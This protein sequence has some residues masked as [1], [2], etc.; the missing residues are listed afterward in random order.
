MLFFHR[1]TSF[2]RWDNIDLQNPVSRKQIKTDLTNPVPCEQIKSPIKKP[3]KKV[4]HITQMHN[5]EHF[6]ITEEKLGPQNVEEICQS[7]FLVAQELVKYMHLPIISEDATK[8]DES[9]S[10]PDY[11]ACN[12]LILAVFPEGL[13]SYYED[14]DNTQKEMLYRIGGIR[15]LHYLGQIPTL[16]SANTH[17]GMT[18]DN[19]SQFRSIRELEAVCNAYLITERLNCDTAVIVYGV[20]HVKGFK[21]L[22]EK[23]AVVYEDVNT[24]FNRKPETKPVLGKAEVT[25]LDRLIQPDYFSAD[26]VRIFKPKKQRSK[27]LENAY[28]HRLNTIYEM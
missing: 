12:E 9:T 18:P 16:Y 6:G 10:S 5:L 26:S 3:L 19:A 27:V 14:L 20:G 25:Y 1:L 28:P 13:P 21:K 8:G 22:C 2:A 11:L 23:F 24:T 7:Q 17:Y 15:V 4:I